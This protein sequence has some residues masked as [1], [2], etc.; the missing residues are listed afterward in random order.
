MYRT[1]NTSKKMKYRNFLHD[2]GRYGILEVQNRSE[3]SS[4]NP[5]LPKKQTK[6]RGPKQDPP[7]R[8]S[9]DF[10]IHKLEKI[11]AGRR[12]KKTYPARQCK[13]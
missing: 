7:G 11:V 8:L 5:Q 12:E 10:R 1:L 2:V 4:D 6:P 3:S 13:L 9:V